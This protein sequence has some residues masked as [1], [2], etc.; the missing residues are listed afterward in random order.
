[1]RKQLAQEFSFSKN[2]DGTSYKGKKVFI[3][4]YYS[5]ISSI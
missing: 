2:S 5:N 3:G 4:M 1:M